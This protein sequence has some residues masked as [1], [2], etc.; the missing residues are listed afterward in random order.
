MSAVE[1]RVALLVLVG[2][3]ITIGCG[4][5]LVVGDEDDDHFWLGIA[6]VA[7]NSYIVGRVALWLWDHPGLLGEDE[8]TTD[9]R[10]R[11]ETLPDGR[12]VTISYDRP[13]HHPDCQFRIMR[14][15]HPPYWEWAES[16]CVDGC[17]IRQRLFDPAANAKA[18]M[19]IAQQQLAPTGWAAW[20][21]RHGFGDDPLALDPYSPLTAQTWPG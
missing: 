17:P 20:R 4:V 16:R 6:V 21:S 13:G 5:Y 10:P 8:S 11:F 3:I 19:K 9:E 12:T 1:R 18:A 14:P 15:P 7:I 2:A